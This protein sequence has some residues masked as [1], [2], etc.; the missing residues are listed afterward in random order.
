MRHKNV[1]PAEPIDWS[2]SDAPARLGF[3]V[4]GLGLGVFFF[5]AAF[6]PLDEGV[7]SP[8]VVSIDTKRRTVQHLQGGS[9]KELFVREGQSVDEGQPLLLLDDS[10]VR[11]AYEAAKQSLAVLRENVVA[12]QAIFDGLRSAEK[13]RLHQLELLRRSEVNRESQ[14]ALSSRE[15]E[16]V[17][18]LVSE[19]YAPLVQ[20]LQLERAFSE[21]QSSVT[22]IQRL[23]AE[24]ATSLSDIGTNQR[25]SVQ[26]SLEL[27][28]Q[29]KSAQQQLQTSESELERLLIRSNARGHVVGISIA[30]EGAVI[31][32]GQR[33]MDIVP[34][35]EILTIE[36]QVP[37]HYIDRVSAGQIVDV[38]FSNFA[39]DPQLVVEG[40]L[41]SI[42]QDVLTDSVT[43]QSFYLARVSL[44]RNGVSKLG[45]RVMQP[46]MPAELI[47]KT[48]SK[49]L[50]SYLVGP[51]TRRLA[52]SM[53]ED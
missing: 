42:S 12:Q 40:E 51:L 39:G 19:G 7:P 26:S 45:N 37:P 10:K 48:G 8:G 11:A 31:Q 28:H 23:Q 24:V 35:D 5:W 41:L 22:D 47:I 14:L 21:L 15:L 36:A 53:K 43:S 1:T 50:L 30:V 9:V 34:Q 3:K 46:G 33:V 17:R 20:Q 27:N 18:D 38:R 44:T 6:A 32:P 2:N 29:I 49:T 13:N 25:R 52:S 4:L 16:G